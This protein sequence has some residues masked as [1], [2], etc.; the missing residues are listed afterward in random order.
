TTTWMFERC[1]M[2]SRVRWIPIPFAVGLLALTLLLAVRSAGA[3]QAAA[4]VTEPQPDGAALPKGEGR[5]VVVTVCAECHG[6]KTALE[7]RRTRD[8]WQDVLDEMID[9]GAKLND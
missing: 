4:A 2:R 6:L 3:A 8:G 1:V 7:D 5:D 9:L